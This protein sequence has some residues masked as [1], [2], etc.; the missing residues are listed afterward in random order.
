MNTVLHYTGYDDDRGGIVT[1][2]RN[3]AAAGRVRCM[4]GMNFG[5]VQQRRPRLETLEFPWIE[6]EEIGP[7]NFWRA[8]A[9]ARAVQAWLHAD[10]TRVFHGHSRAGLL[11]GL[12][13]RWFGERHAVVSVH[14]YGRHRWFY[15][16]VARRL[17]SRLFWLS[18]AMR[19]YYGVSGLEWAQCIPGGV[20][21][22]TVMR[23]GPVSGRLRLGGVGSLVR[24]KGWHHLI[25]ALAALPQEA[26]ARVT[27]THIGDGEAAYLQELQHQVDKSG[28]AGQVNFRGAE[29]SPDALLGEIDLLVITSVNEPFPMAMLEALAA[30]V[31][32]LAADS[33]GARD[34]IQDG[35]NGALYPQCDVVALAAQLCRWLAQPPAWNLDTIRGTTIPID[36]VARQWEEVYAAL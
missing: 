5:G 31:P 3:L 6:G 28:L 20:P 9:V 15:R 11:V 34:V 18:P 16:W 29:P 24:W 7:F 33:G 25:K 21:V 30:G 19:T 4:L 26:R 36:R 35:V 14:C 10:D 23:V 22:A 17:G 1:V 8:Y 32:V 12:W 27:F 2:I 13:L